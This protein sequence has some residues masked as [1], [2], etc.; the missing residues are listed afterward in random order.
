MSAFDRKLGCDR[1]VI[2]S[3]LRRLVG[4]LEGGVA[5][6]NDDRDFLVSGI[7]VYLSSSSGVSLDQALGLR[8][9]G[10]VSVRRTLQNNE[11][12]DLIRHL[13]R[14]HPVWGAEP[15]TIAARKVR[16]AFEAYE[17]SRWLRDRHAAIAPISEPQATFWRLLKE[18]MRMPQQK[19]LSQIL[20]MEIQ[21]PI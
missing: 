5:L 19:R 1:R 15:P 14:E 13:V 20:D 3:R 6:D 18:D 11:R 16:H 8:S 4:Y 21:Y 12:D 2:V 9:R 7:E 10:G 17:S